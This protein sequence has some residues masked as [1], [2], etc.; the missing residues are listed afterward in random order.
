MIGF[1]IILGVELGDA[2]LMFSFDNKDQ[3]VT[4]NPV[5]IQVFPPLKVYPRNGTLLI[6][7]TLQLTLKG[8]PQP[9][10]NIEF[11]PF[12]TATIGK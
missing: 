5:E 6:G 3:V 11:S 4:S 8:G 2:R 10:T 7:S 12:S 9:D 1:L